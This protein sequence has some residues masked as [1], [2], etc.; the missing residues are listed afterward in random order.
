M[1]WVKNAWV[2]S[3]QD[4][5]WQHEVIY[6]G[7][8]PGAGHR[9]H[10]DLNQGT[11]VDDDDLEGLGV[12]ELKALVRELQNE[13]STVV[14]EDRPLAAELH[15]TMKPVGLVA[16]QIANSSRRG[17]IVYEPFAGSGTTLIAAENLGRRCYA[18]EVEPGYADV[19]VDR[20]ERHTGREA[21]R[22][23]PAKAA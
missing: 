13:R 19:V 15:P 12:K 8:K 14:R 10:G 9:F 7:W 4:Y 18:V 6:Y 22:N 23:A 1:M 3:R 11:V 17:E 16:R 5:H 21:S 2:L 20:W